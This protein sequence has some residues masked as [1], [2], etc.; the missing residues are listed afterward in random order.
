LAECSST[1]T[2]AATTVGPRY[3]FTIRATI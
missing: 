1:G 3:K 2:I